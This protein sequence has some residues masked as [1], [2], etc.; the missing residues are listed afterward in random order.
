MMKMLTMKH[1]CVKEMYHAYIATSHDITVLFGYIVSRQEH[2]CSI[3]AF[4]PFLII[5]YTADEADSNY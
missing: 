5:F 2:E 3:H 4:V 1:H